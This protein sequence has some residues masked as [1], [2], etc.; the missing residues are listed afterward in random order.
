MSP[1]VF[2]R[3]R[4]NSHLDCAAMFPTVL[5]LLVMCVV[6]FV[7]HQAPVGSQ[8]T[9]IY[10]GDSDVS[11]MTSLVY[12]LQYTDER[13][14]DSLE[15]KQREIITLNETVEQQQREMT[16]LRETVDRQEQQLTRLEE[17][18]VKLNE[19]MCSLTAPGPFSINLVR[20]I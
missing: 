15:Q 17:T 4:R 18:L 7:M 20:A 5:S 19:S 12:R 6:S 14:Q 13:L 1:F 3:C 16:T 9:R 2:Q 11:D 8:D 10:D